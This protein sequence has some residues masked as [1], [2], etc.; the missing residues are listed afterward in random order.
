MHPGRLITEIHV[1]QNDISDIF[2]FY[3]K[4]L[5]SNLTESFFVNLS[6]KKLAAAILKFLHFQL[7]SSSSFQMSSLTFPANVSDISCPRG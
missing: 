1:V 7:Q 3:H 2:Y 4:A 5:Q 6:K